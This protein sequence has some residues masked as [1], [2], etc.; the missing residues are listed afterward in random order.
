MKRI[1]L[2]LFMVLIAQVA[3]PQLT[4]E[5]NFSNG[6]VVYT[7]IN[8]KTTWE[9]VKTY[10]DTI[11][12]EKD[13]RYQGKLPDRLNYVIVI[14]QR[15]NLRE[16]PTTKSEIV[17]SAPNG[18][19]MRVLEEVINREGEKWY[20]VE[21]DKGEVFVYSKIVGLRE[22][23]FQE[24]LEKIRELETFIGENL[25]AG[26]EIASVNTYVPNP[27]NID[28]KRN[29]D[30]Y[31]NVKDQSATGYYEDL[32][33]YV[34]D[35]TIVAIEEEAGNRYRVSK[36]GGEEPYLDIAKRRISKK[37][38]IDKMPRKAVV[39]DVK[40]QNFGVYENEGG[41]WKLIS[42]AYSKTGLISKLGFKTPKGSFIVPIVRR[43]MIYTDVEGE[44]QGTAKYAIRFS[45]GGYIHGTP[46]DLEEEEE[47]DRY[48][49]LKESTLG[50]Y[51][52]TRK[53]VRNDLEHAEFLFH[54]VV[55]Y[56][57]KLGNN[58]TPLEN[59]VVIV[60]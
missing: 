47:F 36:L 5:G 19:R 50:S 26:K 18:K 40:N 16:Q 11:E 21:A 30:K 60:M 49:R 9:V 55:G 32:E 53:C 34:P 12:V 39:I 7:D 54:W 59:T 45:G 13:I 28:F 43:E 51:P 2:L 24:K 58:Q 35:R 29:K 8:K 38:L 31:G 6:E 48:K 1:M 46:F 41:R 22:F 4:S 14:S 44:K 23:R 52:G 56:D 17:G 20:R 42:Y 57:L 25:A 37:P 10:D 27:Q 33:V 15:I 3:Y